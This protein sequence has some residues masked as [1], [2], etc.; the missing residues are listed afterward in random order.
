MFSTLSGASAASSFGSREPNAFGQD[1]AR[2][3]SFQNNKKRG[4]RHS[5]SNQNVCDRGGSLFDHN[6]AD[7]GQ[8]ARQN[9]KRGR[10]DKKGQ[11]GSHRLKQRPAQRWQPLQD[12][13]GPDES[14]QSYSSADESS[15]PPSSMTPPKSHD[16][17]AKRIYDRLRKDGIYPPPWPSKPGEAGSSSEMAQFREL[18]DAYRRKARASLTRAGLID[19]PEKRKRLS[20]AI[21]FKGICDDMCPEFE[22]ITRITEND[23]NKPER[24]GS[25]GVTSVHMMVKKLARSAAGQEAP[26]PMDVRSA[27]ALRLSLD[28]LMDVVLCRDENLSSVHPFLWDRTRAIRRDFAFFSSMTEQEIKTQVYVLENITRFHVT[29]LHLLSRPDQEDDKF[30]EQQELEQLGKTLLSLRDVYDD[31][32]GQGIKC[33]NEAEFRAYYLLFHGRDPSILETLQRQWKPDLWRDSDEIRT[34]V[35]LVEALQNTQEFI[36][37]R[38]DGDAGPLLA[39]SGAQLSYFRIVEDAQVSYTMACFAEC[40]FPHLR[41]S[42]LAT[43]K[44]ALA[45]PKDPVQEVTAAALN[46]FL[47]LDT[48]TE[49]IQFAQ[50]HHLEFSP[51]ERNPMDQGSQFLMLTDRCPLPHVRLSHQ[52]S[53]S[54]VEGKRGQASLPNL[55]HSTVFEHT[56]LPHDAR[57]GVKNEAS[58]F[59]P[60]DQ[61]FGAGPSSNVPLELDRSSNAATPAQAPPSSLLGPRKLSPPKHPF[62]LESDTDDDDAPDGSTVAQPQQQ[63]NPFAAKPNNLGGSATSHEAPSRLPLP[64]FE[65]VKAM[66]SGNFLSNMPKSHAG[67]FGQNGGG[68]GSS[69]DSQPAKPNPFSSR[70]RLPGLSGGTVAGAEKPNP[71]A[72]LPGSSTG[73]KTTTGEL[74]GVKMNP[75]VGA[76]RFASNAATNGNTTSGMT[77]SNKSNPFGPV[78]EPSSGQAPAAETQGL[79][80]NQAKP[81][82]FAS[83]ASPG[84][85]VGI[86]PASA[87]LVPSGV[88]AGNKSAGP[89]APAPFGQ[90]P[91][92]AEAVGQAASGQKALSQTTTP[93]AVT[94]NGQTS[95]P[96][97]PAVASPLSFG[98]PPV[99]IPPS[100]SHATTSEP[101]SLAA[102]LAVQ[103]TTAA[104]VGE[105]SLQSAAPGAVPPSTALLGVPP[106]SSPGKTSDAAA[107][108]AANLPS[109]A[110]AESA[111]ASPP[112]DLLGDLNKWYVKGD[113]GLLADF[114][115]DSISRITKAAFDTFQQ[116]V[117]EQKRLEEEERVT[118]EVETF[119]VYNLRLKFFYR[120]KRNARAKRLR[121]VGRKG[122]DEMRAYYAARRAAERDAKQAMAKDAERLVRSRP[123]ELMHLVKSRRRTKREARE[124]LLASGVLSGVAQ[125]REAAKM[126]VNGDSRRPDCSQS[127][128]EPSRAQPQKEGPK[129]RALRKLYFGQPERFRRSLPSMPSSRGSPDDANRPSNASS[130]WTLKAMGIVQLPDGTAVPESLAAELASKMPRYPR[131]AA[132]S[133]A[134]RVSATDAIEAELQRSTPSSSWREGSSMAL[135]DDTPPTNKGKKPLGDQDSMASASPE[136]SVNKRIMGS[137]EKARMASAAETSPMN[138]RKRPASDD[139]DETS[140]N[141]ETE[142]NSHK[143]IMSDAETI[144]MELRA[145]RAE[146]EEGTEWF[147]AQN[148]RLRDD[149][150]TATPWYDDD[151]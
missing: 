5:D 10:P 128:L 17:F 72:S 98:L 93:S 49:A 9:P 6:K 124:S 67:A 109:A 103:S 47:R 116:E 22:K 118:A 92:N 75:F 60:E 57:N 104:I 120:W 42:I 77:P 18:H 70:L 105:P 39:A 108:P 107:T 147:R 69:G 114:L 88:F 15:P 2:G 11:D 129:T 61:A 12:T 122:R 40:H 38:K 151:I 36:G 16:H 19:D 87:P 23:V 83:L 85:T 71:F 43:V 123:D 99:A 113:N 100:A 35:S 126:I 52:F 21:E 62:I 127:T 131:S 76:I 8:A 78:S 125:E 31:C 146:L 134:R 90:P 137:T 1:G 13:T 56:S 33:E 148:E 48:V 145:L 140:N 150:E 24:D 133:R 95:G 136:G 143:R 64:T 115:A 37:S 26:L 68:G 121:E 50:L 117:E 84:N 14:L 110:A 119:R 65:E 142:A 34:A 28:Y 97:A 54:L 7:R 45:R 79:G 94:T 73:G 53:Q 44:R 55:I 80:S 149:S 91:K 86:P 96:G 63:S 81:N 106:V 144:R 58:L 3:G 101:A 138:K 102:S 132:S 25:T 59:M 141:G 30:V 27:S 66:D 4:P 130:R 139:D 32:A 74:T 112:R 111:P 135:V 51:D 20:D 41:R 89:S 29:S 82:P 46:G